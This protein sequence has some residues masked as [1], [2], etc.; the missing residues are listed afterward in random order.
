MQTLNEI[1]SVYKLNQSEV[2]RLS[3]LAKQDSIDCGRS[4]AIKELPKETW[5]LFFEISD[6][7]WYSSMATSQKIKSGFQLYEVFPNYYHFLTPFYHSIRNKEVT[8]SNE[9]EIIWKHFMKYLA[10]ENFYADPVGYVLWVDFFE[11]QSLVHEAWTGLMKF[12]DK[13]AV[14]RL[15]EQSGPVPYELKENLYKTLIKDDESHEAIFKSLFFSAYDIYGQISKGKAR[16]L[17]KQLNLD[18][19]TENYKLLLKKL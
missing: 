5:N 10:S 7:V 19:T 4:G 15:L 16:D 12:Y 6:K 13:K 2:E 9:K 11:D 14:L 1:F 8:D 3:N 18:R 17:L